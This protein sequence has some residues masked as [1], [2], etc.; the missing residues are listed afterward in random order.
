[1]SRIITPRILN[2]TESAEYL[3]LS[4]EAFDK[5]VNVRP[6]PLQ[7]VR[8]ER[9]D[10]RDLDAWV[11]ELKT[12]PKPSS[13]PSNLKNQSAMEESLQVNHGDMLKAAIHQA[14]KT[15]KGAVSSAF[16]TVRSKRPK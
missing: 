1:M 16:K 2:K 11:D 3:G 15:N 5:L 4:L 8:G 13:S 10:V 7:G 14:T 6:L 9:Y 12:K